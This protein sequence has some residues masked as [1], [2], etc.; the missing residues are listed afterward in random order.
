[1]LNLLSNAVK[2]TPSGGEVSLCARNVDGKLQLVVRDNGIGIP[3]K[4]LARIG[5]AFEQ[6][7]NDPMCAREGTGLGLALVKSLADRHGGRM[8]ITSR[9]NAG[10]TVLV[11]IPF[12]YGQRIAA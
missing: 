1:M 9:E 6:A 3:E 5:T 2:F 4:S 7:D 10:T 11:E 12:V 8:Q